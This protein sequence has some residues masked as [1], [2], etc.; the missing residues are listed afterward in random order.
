MPN[1]KQH[2]FS[3]RTTEAG[4]KALNQLKAELGVSWDKLVVDAVCTHYGL[5][6]SVLMLPTSGRPR[7]T[8]EERKA[9]RTESSAKHKAKKAAKTAKEFKKRKKAKKAKAAATKVTELG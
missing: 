9:H 4:L 5:E 6:S 1:D 7:L 8:D 3:A 2:V